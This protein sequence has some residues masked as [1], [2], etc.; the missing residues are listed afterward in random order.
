MNAYS[1][2]LSSISI[3]QRGFE[4]GRDRVSKEQGKYRFLTGSNVEKYCYKYI[5]RSIPV[6]FPVAYKA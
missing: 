4:V 6:H 3:M 2:P 1:K 5:F